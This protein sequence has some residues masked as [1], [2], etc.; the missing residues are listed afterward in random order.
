M[1]LSLILGLHVTLMRSSENGKECL[2][3]KKDDFVIFV[4]EANRDENTVR[5]YSHT[6]RSEDCQHSPI[7]QKGRL[8]Y[9]FR[10]PFVRL[11]KFY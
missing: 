6:D 1:V 10:R 11:I 3:L 7:R 5:P 2:V 4:K 8:K 9:I